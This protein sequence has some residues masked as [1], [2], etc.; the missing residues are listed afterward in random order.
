M[1]DMESRLTNLEKTV[2]AIAARQKVN[3]A[4]LVIGLAASILRLF[5]PGG[6][7]AH[8]PAPANTNSVKI[9]VAEERQADR[10]YLTVADMAKR[11]D[12]SPRT[13]TEWIAQGRFEP[14]PAKT[15]RAWIFAADSRIQP[16]TTADS[17]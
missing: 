4:L 12:V 2:D 6:F 7:G 16:P 17:R 11:L 10:E 5:F 15:D 9:G 3:T 8:S 1:T 14:P 13:V